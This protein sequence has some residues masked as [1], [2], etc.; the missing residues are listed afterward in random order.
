M[1]FLLFVIV[2][3]NFI[4]VELDTKKNLAKLIE[5]GIKLYVVKQF[6]TVLNINA[7][8]ENVLN[9]AFQRKYIY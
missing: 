2:D 6:E 5:K 1:N 3:L 9:L 4:D 8:S 7:C